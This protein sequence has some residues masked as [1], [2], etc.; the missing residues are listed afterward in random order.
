MARN[1]AGG[2]G[3]R[4][5]VEFS[6]LR[7][8]RQEFSD[9]AN[10]ISGIQGNRLNA[11]AEDIL[12]SGLADISL[13]FRDKIRSV[14][15][16]KGVPKR[17]QNAAFAFTDIAKATYG[18]KMRSGTTYR[19]RS[20]L[21]G[22]RKGAPPWTD[23]RLYVEWRGTGKTIGMSLATIFEKGTKNKRIKP[24]W[25]FRTAYFSARSVVLN[26]LVSTYKS[27]IESFRGR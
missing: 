25:Y 6:N 8:V 17:V 13:F 12:N 21:V 1:V 7:D 5:A 18:H 23:E 4:W 26:R 10:T 19:E 2:G 9:I 27:A 16:S 24:R 20:S 3:K 11:R 15:A 14:A 22:V